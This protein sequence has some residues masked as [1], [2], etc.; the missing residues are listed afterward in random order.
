MN[1]AQL[2][3]S[4]FS[5]QK[6]RENAMREGTPGPLGKCLVFGCANFDLIHTHAMGGH[7]REGGSENSSFDMTLECFFAQT[8]SFFASH[9]RFSLWPTQS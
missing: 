2:S 4:G 5:L 6:N 8:C 1:T 3:M 9:S 7:E